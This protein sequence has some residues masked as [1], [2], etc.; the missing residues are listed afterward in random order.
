LEEPELFNSLQTNLPDTLNLETRFIDKANEWLELIRKKDSAAL[1]I[2]M[3]QLKSKLKTISGNIEHSYK[4]MYK[5]L[6]SSE[7]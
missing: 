5:M 1:T 4:V 2:K 6:E 3:K 7:N